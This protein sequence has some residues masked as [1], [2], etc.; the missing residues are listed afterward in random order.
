MLGSFKVGLWPDV[1]MVT[2]VLQALPDVL[3]VMPRSANPKE[4]RF[5]NI[6][7]IQ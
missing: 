7:W 3:F 5:E 6:R 4:P 2:A 1:S